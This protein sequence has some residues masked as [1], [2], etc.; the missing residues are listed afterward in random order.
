MLP[1]QVFLQNKEFSPDLV[2]IINRKFSKD[3]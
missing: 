3:C 1:I 2:A